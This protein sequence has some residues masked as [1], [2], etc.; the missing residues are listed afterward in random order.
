MKF[1]RKRE[2]G[3]EELREGKETQVEG[4]RWK[5]RGKV[6]EKWVGRRGNKRDQNKSRINEERAK[7]RTKSGGR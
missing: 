6:R 5:G 4:L 2:V 3:V 1:D 7:W